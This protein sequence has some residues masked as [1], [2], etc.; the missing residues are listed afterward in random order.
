MKKALCLISSGIDSPVAAAMMFEKLEITF[1][2]FDN[3]PF[4][5]EIP[6]IKVVEQLQKLADKYNKEL[7]LY[8]IAHG[9]NQAQYMKNADRRYQCVY[10][11]RMMLRISERIAKDEKIDYLLTGENV[12]Q[13]ASQTLDN[14]VAEDKVID[15]QVI[16]PLLTED[17]NNIVKVA[18]ELG[19][20]DVSVQRDVC[21]F[22]VPK[23]PATRAKPHQ[24]EYQETKVDVK[25]IVEK[26]ILEKEIIMI[27]PA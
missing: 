21:C 9:K 6:R 4:T 2:H 16:R 7:K 26:S 23:N 3:Q 24:L 27:K 18:K 12:G 13:V 1:I 22:A 19:T 17:K 5:N 15:I 14:M 20:Y 10:C 8:I 25:G 11:R